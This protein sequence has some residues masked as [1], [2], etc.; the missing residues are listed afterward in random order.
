MWEVIEVR[1]S[2]I[3]T[4]SEDCVVSEHVLKQI[5]V[6]VGRTIIDSRVFTIRKPQTLRVFEDTRLTSKTG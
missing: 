4:C 2:K 3:S 5:V 1:T 6:I